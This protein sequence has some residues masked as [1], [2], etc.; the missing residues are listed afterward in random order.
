MQELLVEQG[1]SIHFVQAYFGN[2]RINTTMDYIDMLLKEQIDALAQNP[3]AT[4]KNAT[5]TDPKAVA[6]EQLN[7]LHVDGTINALEYADAMSKVS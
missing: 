1:S 7:A 2:D 3:K 5:G 4:H 6:V